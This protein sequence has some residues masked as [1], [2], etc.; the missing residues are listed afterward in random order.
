MVNECLL[1]IISSLCEQI[2]TG[3]KLVA[4]IGIDKTYLAY[5]KKIIQDENCKTLFKIRPYKRAVLWIYKYNFVAVLIKELYFNKKNSNYKPSVSDIWISGK[6]FGYSDF[7]IG[8][9]L[10]EHGYINEPF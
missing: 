7:E 8:K 4:E 9:Y 1:G 2:N 3:T 5:A 6:L 10:K